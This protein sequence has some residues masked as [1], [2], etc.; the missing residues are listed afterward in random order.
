[1]SHHVRCIFEIK[2][3]VWADARDI[4]AHAKAEDLAES[5]FIDQYL[6]QARALISAGI[7][8]PSCRAQNALDARF[9]NKCGAAVPEPSPEA[10][11][12]EMKRLWWS[13]NHAEESLPEHARILRGG[14][15]EVFYLGE[16]DVFGGLLIEDGKVTPCSVEMKLV[17]EGPP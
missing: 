3:P 12:V 10:L 4:V 13:G 8:C 11:R 7:R 14:R 6:K 17:P 9:C 1:M 15:I 2:E 5:N 16:E